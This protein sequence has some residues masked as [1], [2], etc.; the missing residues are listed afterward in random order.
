MYKSCLLSLP[1]FVTVLAACSPTPPPAASA[2][3]G[4]PTES[5]GTTGA[6]DATVVAPV[7]DTW[8]LPDTPGTRAQWEARF[9]KENLR[10]ETRYGPEGEGEYPVLVL[11]PD[12]A[13]KRLVLDLDAD[14][15]DAAVTGVSVSDA[16]SLWHEASGLRVGMPL[17][18][19]VALNGASISFFGLDWDYGGT[20]EDWHD[21]RLGNPPGASRFRAVTLVAREGADGDAVPVGDSSFRSDDA[22]WPGIGK[23]LLV[24]EIGIHWSMDGTP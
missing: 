9:G 23:D 18:E 2:P 10:A 3:E 4:V 22:Q 14:R 19:L 21:G 12:D 20:V 17:A 16:E 7:V 8:E 11:F 1:L 24:G 13:R 6:G 5:A 15:A